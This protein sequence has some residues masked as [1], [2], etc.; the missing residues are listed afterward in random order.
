M[1]TTIETQNLH[2]TPFCQSVPF[3][4]IQ[5][6]GCY[7]S[8]DDGNLYRV[9]PEALAQG[10]SPLIE[11]VSKR[12]TIMAKVSDD[13]WLPISR[14]RQLAADADVQPNF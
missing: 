14:A 5:T 13:P 8:K 12:G 10:R 2:P 9:P 1:A 11:I 3:H 7:V 4:E 6:P